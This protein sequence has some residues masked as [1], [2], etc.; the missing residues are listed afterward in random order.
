METVTFVLVMRM[1]YDGPY[2]HQAMTPK[3]ARMN[4]SVLSPT[5]LKIEARAQPRRN[6]F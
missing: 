6:T 3:Q 2:Q 1:K 5:S 4:K